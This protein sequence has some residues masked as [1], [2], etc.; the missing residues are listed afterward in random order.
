MDSL[1]LYSYDNRT[2]QSSSAAESSSQQQSQTLQS[3]QQ[4][5]Q[6]QQQTHSHSHTHHHSYQQL[7][8]NKVQLPSL[9]KLFP[10][11]PPNTSSVSQGLQSLSLAPVAG[12]VPVSS[13]S[14][15]SSVSGPSSGLYQNSPY[16]SVS[17]ANSSNV[18]LPL[19]SSSSSTSVS[20]AAGPT[21]ASNPAGPTVPM[22]SYSYQGQNQNQNPVYQQEQ[23]PRQ[24]SFQQPQLSPQMMYQNQYPP[25]NLQNEYAFQQQQQQQPQQQQQQSLVSNHRVVSQPPT[26]QHRQLRHHASVSQLQTSNHHRPHHHPQQLLYPQPGYYSN[27]APLT[28]QLP[29]Q[30]QTHIQSPSQQHSHSHSHST[31]TS[32]TSRSSSTKHAPNRFQCD[33]CDKAYTRKHNLISHK[34]SV[35]EKEKLFQCLKC[36][37]KFSRASDLSRHTKEQH[38]KLIKPFVCGGVNADGTTWGCGKRFYRKD[39]L[40]SHLGTNKAESK[41][42]KRSNLSAKF[43]TAGEFN[44]NTFPTV[45]ELHGQHP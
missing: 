1:R 45:Y 2:Y 42:F 40:R 26:T 22:Y 28:A 8:P 38:S 21:Y 20:Q 7:P 34:L 23:V 30:S 10:N 35:H 33:L 25:Q 12:P 24:V 3:Q 14:G 4:Q 9:D 41:C 36:K 16:N 13:R 31:A 11:I 27:T 29:I 6:Q 44:N 17:V 37:V 18:S 15:S 32:S 39:Q 43:L 19:P 5:Q